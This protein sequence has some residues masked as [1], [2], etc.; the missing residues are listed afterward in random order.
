ME[1]FYLTKQYVYFVVRRLNGLF[2]VMN[3]IFSIIFS[4]QVSSFTPTANIQPGMLAFCSESARCCINCSIV[5]I[6]V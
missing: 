6:Y 2:R 5:S 3:F 4:S 1:G